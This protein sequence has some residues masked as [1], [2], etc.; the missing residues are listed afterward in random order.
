MHI[1]LCKED[2]YQSTTKSLI[3][4]IKKDSTLPGFTSCNALKGTLNHGH[5]SRVCFRLSCDY[6]KLLLL[7]PLCTQRP[8][9]R[10]SCR[11][12]RKEDIN[13]QSTHTNSNTNINTNTRTHIHRRIHHMQRKSLPAGIQDVHQQNFLHTKMTKVAVHVKQRQ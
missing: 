13:K 7:L 12:P 1:C 11:W 4:I 8:I 6:D 2:Y 3:R 5:N 9:Q 10:S